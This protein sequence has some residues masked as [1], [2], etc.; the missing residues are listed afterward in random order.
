MAFTTDAAARYPSRSRRS[1]TLLV[2]S[3]DQPGGVSSTETAA[4]ARSSQ[5]GD[6]CKAQLK[7]RP[8]G[9]FRPGQMLASLRLGRR[10]SNLPVA[11]GHSRNV[12]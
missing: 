12:G 7:L 3:L 2:A 5:L 11:A 1:T 4:I 9:R 6:V 10:R 8:S